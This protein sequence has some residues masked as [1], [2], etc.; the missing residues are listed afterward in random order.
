MAVE[1]NEDDDSER[2]MP[3]ELEVKRSFSEARRERTE[4]EEGREGGMD[5]FDSGS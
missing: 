5:C 4:K 1:A 3:P 2:D